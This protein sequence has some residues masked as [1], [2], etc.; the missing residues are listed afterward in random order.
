MSPLKNATNLV[1]CSGVI[2]DSDVKACIALTLLNKQWMLPSQS[3]K[4]L[5]GGPVYMQHSLPA[6]VRAGDDQP[7]AY[8]VTV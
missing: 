5:T 7:S 4:A 8:S 2:G 1:T 6:G 3:P